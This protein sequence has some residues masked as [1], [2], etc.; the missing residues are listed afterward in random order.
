M[1]SLISVS[2]KVKYINAIAETV[3]FS[4][5]VWGR[6]LPG[7]RMTKCWFVY[8]IYISCQLCSLSTSHK[9]LFLLHFPSSGPPTS[10]EGI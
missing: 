2:L 4:L 9:R 5:Q 6:R 10:K 7:T 8:M 1:N 3:E